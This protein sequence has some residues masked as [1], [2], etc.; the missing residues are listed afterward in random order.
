MVRQDGAGGADEV[1]EACD[2]Q[3]RPALHHLLRDIGAVAVRPGPA[4]AHD[5][6]HAAGLELGLEDRQAARLVDEPQ[7]RVRAPDDAGARGEIRTSTSS[8]T[9][10]RCSTPTKSPTPRPPYP[11]V[12]STGPSSGPTLGTSPSSRAWAGTTRLPLG[13]G[14]RRSRPPRACSA[15]PSPRRWPVASGPGARPRGAARPAPPCGAPCRRAR[16]A[17]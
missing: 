7:R 14:G 15:A 2:P 8:W 10:A 16:Y 12:T 13:R 9:A 17:R 4:G 3:G 6:H 1:L 5:R 11:I